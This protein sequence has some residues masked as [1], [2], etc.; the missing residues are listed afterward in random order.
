ME[1]FHPTGAT[2]KPL[3]EAALLESDPS[4]LPELITIARTAIFDR[5]EE[6]LT[7]PLPSEQR[8]MDEALRRLRRLAE[9]IV[10]RRAA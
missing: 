10:S 5:I 3:Y 8:A 9:T 4:K 2:W 7:H 6:S 1:Q